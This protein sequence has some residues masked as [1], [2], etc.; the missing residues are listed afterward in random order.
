MILAE[1]L[2]GGNAA[3]APYHVV[4]EPLLMLSNEDDRLMPWLA[5]SDAM[6][7][8]GK[9]WRITLRSG[10]TWSDGETVDTEDVDFTFSVVL[11][12]DALSSPNAVNL[13]AEV[14]YLTVVDERTFEV[15]LRNPNP[16]FLHMLMAPR[17][18][19]SFFVLPKHIWEGNVDRWQTASLTPGFF[20]PFTGT[21]PYLLTSASAQELVLER[22]PDWWGVDAGLADLPE[23][24]RVVIRYFES[25]ASAAEAMKDGT[26]DVG[27]EMPYEVF[28]GIVEENPNVIAWSPAA[29]I[30]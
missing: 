28:Q 24:E 17:R 23:P 30:S 10:I 12:N 18:E 1:P 22:N 13:R 27:P 9:N 19:G 7:N 8:G 29:P 26:L 21:G 25:E 2:N 5:E 4:A 11:E 15:T 3:S 20:D 6:R 16:R 14:E